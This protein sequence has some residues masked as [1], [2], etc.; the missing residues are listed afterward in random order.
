MGSPVVPTKIEQWPIAKLIPNARNARTHS[1]KQVAELAG[2]IREFGWTNPALVDEAGDII[3]GHGRVLA[4][5][6]LKMAEVPVIVLSHLTDGQKRALRIA[7]NR[8]AINAGWDEELL[9]IELQELGADGFDTSGLGFDEKELAA[10][11]AETSV[12]LTDPDDSP[13]PEAVAVSRLG[14]IWALGKHRVICG[15]ST[16]EAVVHRLLGG[17]VPGLMVTDPPYGVEYDPGWRNDAVQAGRGEGAPGGRAIGV[18][19]NDD[20][21]DW[22]DAWALF[23]GDVVYCWHAG[24]HASD[25]QASLEE[26]RFEIR[27][28]IIWAKTHLTISRG[29][30]HWQHEPCWYAVRRGKTANWNGDRKQTTLWTIEHRKSETGHSTQKPVEAMRR[31]IENHTN[32]GQC[33]YDPFLGS[34]T[35]VIAAEQTGRVAFGVELSEAYVDVIV[36]RWEAFTGLKASLDGSNESF[37]EV[38]ARRSLEAADASA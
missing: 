6:Q 7:D 15:D 28:Q 33:V 3:A 2:S 27:S 24:R 18:V 19:K 36:K 22:K 37:A 13:E 1:D 10:L 38:T 16:E 34:G 30:Y 26:S 17:V 9:K 5:R 4:A 29:H 11:M 32:P 35:T 8:I 12:G 21:V 25:V 14:D 23:P 31:P 20:R